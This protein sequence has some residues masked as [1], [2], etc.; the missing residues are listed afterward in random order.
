MTPDVIFTNIPALVG[1]VTGII[2]LLISLRAVWTERF[3][4]KISFFENENMYFDRL[5]CCKANRTNLQGIVHIRLLNCSATPITIYSL[6]LFI[7]G[8]P[9]RIEKFDGDSF[10]ITTCLYPD[11][12]SESIEVPMNRQV[13]PPVRLEAYAAE[14]GYVFIPF[15]PDTEKICQKIKIKVK[16]TKGSRNKHSRIWIQ[17]T[18][19]DD[20]DGPFY[21]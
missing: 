5:E 10:R 12:T 6:K 20:G 19:I 11:G 15:Y 4:L 18:I 17:K 14:E 9:V 7:D 21:Q 3:K 16:T 2:S 8:T 13:I 1:C